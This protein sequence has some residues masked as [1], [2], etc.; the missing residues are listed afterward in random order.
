MATIRGKSS[1]ASTPGSFFANENGTPEAS[2]SNT[3]TLQ[4]SGPIVHTSF[5]AQ[6]RA[7]REIARMFVEPGGMDANSPYQRGSVWTAAQRMNLVRSWLSGL[8]VPA[9]VLNRRHGRSWEGSKEHYY[10]VIDGKQRLETA[11]AWFS[12]NLPVPASWFDPEFVETVSETADGPYV[13]YDGLTDVGQR[14]MSNRAF[15]P[16]LE[17]NAKDI[18]AEAEMFDLVNTTGTAQTDDDIEN[19]RAV[20]R[21]G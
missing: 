7:A 12:G 1:A 20:A 21:R 16:V 13:S 11:D 19:A 5:Q 3:T 9:V 2:L 10:G 17:V 6:Q 8:P 14:L 4:T 15:L 18:A